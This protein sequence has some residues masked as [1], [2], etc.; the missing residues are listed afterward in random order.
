MPKTTNPFDELAAMFL[1]GS[2]GSSKPLNASAGAPANGSHHTAVIDTP[3]NQQNGIAT[4][5]QQRAGVELLIVG[6]LPVR[7]NLWLTPYSDLRSREIG[8]TALVRLDSGEPSI[9]LLRTSQQTSTLAV[10]GSM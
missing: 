10:R 6:H 8:A 7:G 1:T 5:G 4:A 2:D 9:Q 3:P